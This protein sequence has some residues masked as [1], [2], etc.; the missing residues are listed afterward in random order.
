MSPAQ[1]RSSTASASTTSASRRSPSSRL[2]SSTPPSF[3][4]A[5]ISLSEFDRSLATGATHC[6]RS[7]RTPPTCTRETLSHAQRP[8]LGPARPYITPSCSAT[9]SSGAPCTPGADFS[10]AR[11]SEVD[12]IRTALAGAS[13][14]GALPRPSPTLPSAHPAPP[15]SHCTPSGASRSA[16]PAPLPQE[17]TSSTLSSPSATLSAP[18]SPAISPHALRPTGTISTAS[19]VRSM[20]YQAHSTCAPSTCSTSPARRSA[21]A[22]GAGWA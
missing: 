1:A 7:G 3:R 19:H 13:F 12:F 6:R 17:Q 14:R 16:N 21:S 15:A 10:A 8:A 18:T 4:S 11:F 5:T 2:P 22:P 20:S 9:T